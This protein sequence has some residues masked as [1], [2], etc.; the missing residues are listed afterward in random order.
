M[1]RETLSAR[2]AAATRTQRATDS[3]SVIVMFRLDTKSV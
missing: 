2:S 1:K 3:G